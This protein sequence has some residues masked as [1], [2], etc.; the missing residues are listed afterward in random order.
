MVC[1]LGQAKPNLEPQSRPCCF[2]F[3]SVNT[4]VMI[5]NIIIILQNLITTV[6]AGKIT[7]TMDEIGA[8]NTVLLEVA[9]SLNCTKREAARAI[10]RLDNERRGHIKTVTGPA[11]ARQIERVINAGGWTVRGFV[12][13]KLP[14]LEMGDGL[15]DL[16]KRG[17]LH[18]SKALILR[19][20]TDPVIQLERAHEV[21]LK[22]ITL[23]E[24]EGRSRTP[25]PARDGG[26]ESELHELSRDASRQLATRVV[27]TRD[28]IRVAYADGEQL[29]DWLEKL[30]VV[31]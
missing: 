12:Q 4:D 19:S 8:V 20:I 3:N 22:K 6:N 18:P 23:K 13:R 11:R 7:S 28:E 29:T 26:L 16:V 10:T 17:L 31:F 9:K 1:D 25:L 21:I 27:I 15:K 2:R 24:L 14:L 5:T 30:G